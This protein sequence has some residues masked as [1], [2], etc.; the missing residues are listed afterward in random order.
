MR[1]AFRFRKPKQWT[2]PLVRCLQW[3]ANSDKWKGREWLLVSTLLLW[4]WG[5]A[6]GDQTHVPS[7][8]RSPLKP[9]S[10]LFTLWLWLLLPVYK[11]AHLVWNIS[12]VL[13]IKKI[14]TRTWAFSAVSAGRCCGSGEL[15]IIDLT[16]QSLF[17]FMETGMAGFDWFNSH[18]R[19]WEGNVLQMNVG[20]FNSTEKN[21]FLYI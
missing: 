3:L 16:L 18:L 11:L 14:N 20:L 21:Y 8:V 5:V 6:V 4:A 19:I 13:F 7:P 17:V 9:A 1:T 2:V 10:I 15:M 12:T